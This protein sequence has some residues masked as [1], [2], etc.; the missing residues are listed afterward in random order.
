MH[1]THRISCYMANDEDVRSGQPK[2]A[3]RIMRV[4]ALEPSQLYRRSAPLH[5]LLRV[6]MANNLQR[7]NILCSI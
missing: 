2:N 7:G 6:R 5:I 4:N 3:I 1:V